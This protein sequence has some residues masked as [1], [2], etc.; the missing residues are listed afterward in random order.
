MP[1]CQNLYR[2][3]HMSKHLD[4]IRERDRQSVK[5]HKTNNRKFFLLICYAL[6]M[7]LIAASFHLVLKVPEPIQD[8]EVESGVENQHNVQQD[9]QKDDWQLVLVNTENPLAEEFTLALVDISNRQV[10]KKIIQPLTQMIQ[11]AHEDGITLVLSEGYRGVQEQQDLFDK[12]IMEY[13][14]QG[15]GAEESHQK[16]LKCVLP[17]GMSEYHTGLA[18]D[19]ATQEQQEEDFSQSAA[20]EWLSSNAKT[21]GFVERYPQ[22]KEDVTGQE[23]QPAHYRFVGKENAQAM[24]KENVCLEEYINNQKQETIISGGGTLG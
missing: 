11:D 15:F 8:E 12:K 2:I 1:K 18:V 23:W 6:G 13:Q 24:A 10:N 21:Y 22:N 7:M 16:A 20:Y 19:F 14:Q 3:N 17:A 4:R 5:S 9:S